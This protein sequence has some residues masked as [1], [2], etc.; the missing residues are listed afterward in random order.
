MWVKLNYWKVDQSKTSK[1]EEIPCAGIGLK[2]LSSIGQGKAISN[3]R[4]SNVENVN[5]VIT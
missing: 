5:K 1:K 4:L 3:R 2:P